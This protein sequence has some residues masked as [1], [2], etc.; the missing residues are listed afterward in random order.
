M[1][2][3]NRS[4]WKNFS[5]AVVENQPIT[6]SARSEKSK[7]R[8]LRRLSIIYSGAQGLY[9]RRSLGLHNQSIFEHSII[10]TSIKN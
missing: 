9:F 2:C 3:A 5:T 6:T 8:R 1:Q 10:R 4:S 7:Q